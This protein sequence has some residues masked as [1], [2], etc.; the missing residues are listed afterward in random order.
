MAVKKVNPN[1][2]RRGFLRVP[3]SKTTRVSFADG[4]KYPALD[5]T[6]FGIS[7]LVRPEEMLRF[8]TG[9]LCHG[10]EF[11]IAGRNILVNSAKVAYVEPGFGALCKV[12]IEF[13]DIPVEDV[14]FLSKYIADKSDVS[15]PKQ[16]SVNVLGTK[17]KARPKAKTKPKPS[18]KKKTKTGTRAKAKKKPV[19]KRR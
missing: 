18:S 14:F 7:F 17:K 11:T 10:A 6:V 3:L 5:L 19:R 9:A 4:T 2:S 15:V 8:P 13:A 16:I 12:A 1:E